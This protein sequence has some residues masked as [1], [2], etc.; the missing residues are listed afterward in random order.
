RLVGQ[1][2]LSA[3]A[4]VVYLFNE[5]IIYM[6]PEARAAV[7][8]KE[9]A[10]SYLSLINQEPSQA[11]ADTSDQLKLLIHSWGIDINHLDHDVW[12]TVKQ[13]P[14][15]SDSDLHL[16]FYVERFCQF[17]YR[18]PRSLIRKVRN[19]LVE[20]GNLELSKALDPR[21]SAFPTST[22]FKQTAEK[23]RGYCEY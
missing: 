3:K 17:G 1:Q 23:L 2:L 5:E 22:H 15:S 7:I 14:G 6:P 19:Y 11:A 13:R 4:S 16:D 21:Q 9:L 8:A 20:C 12:L 18:P 10:D